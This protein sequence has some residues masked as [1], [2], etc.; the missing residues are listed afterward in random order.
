MQARRDAHVYGNGPHAAVMVG[1]QF[2]VFDARQR[3]ERDNGVVGQSV[4]VHIFAY[5]AA[6]VAAHA[7]LRAVG[8]EYAHAEVCFVRRADEHQTV[9]ADA[10]V[11]LA[12]CHGQ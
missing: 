5:A 10:R 4:F 8:V 12:P 9:A 3:L 11:R 1:V 7:G 2:Q 6:G